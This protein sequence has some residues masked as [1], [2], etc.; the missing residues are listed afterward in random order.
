MYHVSGYGSAIHDPA[1]IVT[2]ND[3]DSLDVYLRSI[4]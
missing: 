1:I 4:N 3:V 2:H